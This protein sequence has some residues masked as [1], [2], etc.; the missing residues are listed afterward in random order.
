MDELRRLRQ[1][2]ARLRDLQR[3]SSIAASHGRIS[4]PRS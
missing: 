4:F 2:N 3:Q 1:E